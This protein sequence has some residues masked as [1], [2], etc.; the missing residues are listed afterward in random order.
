M[1]ILNNWKVLKVAAP[2][3]RTL[4]CIEGRVYGSKPRF[5]CSSLIRTSSVVGYQQEASSLVIITSRGSEYLLGKPHS[6][7]SFTEQQLMDC[8][9]KKEQAPRAKFDARQTQIIG[10]APEAESGT[11]TVMISEGP[12]KDDVRK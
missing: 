6:A 12:T 5:P 11:E 10:A 7:E 8:L 9:P 2:D 4:I 3:G 1:H